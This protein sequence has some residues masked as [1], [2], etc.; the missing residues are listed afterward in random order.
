MIETGEEWEVHLRTKVHKRLSGKAKGGMSGKERW[1]ASVRE[2]V[3]VEKVQWKE[4]G[5]VEANEREVREED[6]E[7]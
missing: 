7:V 1:E 5:K 4:R 6:D 3:H 2:E